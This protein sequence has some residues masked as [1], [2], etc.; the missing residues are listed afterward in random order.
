MP[1]AEKSS[2]E[3]NEPLAEN[4][5]LYQLGVIP[6]QLG[7][8]DEKT[9]NIKAIAERF[10]LTEDAIDQALAQSWVQDELFVPLKIIEPT[11]EMPTGTSLKKR[12]DGL[13]L[14]EKPLPS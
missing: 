1:H 14:L 5:T 2:T 9:A 3:N 13:I 12:R 6:G 4:G 10:D 11:D 7:T 8:G